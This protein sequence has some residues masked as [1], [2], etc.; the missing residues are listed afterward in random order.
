MSQVNVVVYILDSKAKTTLISKGDVEA[1]DPATGVSHV[2]RMYDVEGH[3]FFAS[4]RQFVVC[5][6]QRRC[7]S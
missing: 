6:T 1:I 4:A 7:T 3:L 5:W 2:T